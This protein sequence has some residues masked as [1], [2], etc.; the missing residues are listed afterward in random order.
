MKRKYFLPFLLSSFFIFQSQAQEV[1]G[2]AT[3]KS[4]RKVDIELD[5]TQMNDEMRA[6]VLAMLKKNFEKEYTLDF[7]KDESIYKEVENLDK[8]SVSTGGMEFVVATAGGSDILYKNTKE[9]KFVNQNDLFG[10]QFLIEDALENLDWQLEK[11]TKNIGEYT[12]FKAIAKRMVPVMRVIESSGDEEGVLEEPQEEEITLTAWYTPQIPVKH[13]PS[14]YGGLPGLI[15]EVS[16]GR[17]TILCSKIVLNPKNDVN[18]TAPSKG[19]KVSQA[20]FDEIMEKKMKEMDERFKNNRRGD[21]NNVE[22]RIG[23]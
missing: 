11:E 17:E 16:D 7:T 9:N 13:G 4:Q 1:K 10:K 8:P 6:Q 3:Y 12:C 23:G 21:G 20:E 18:V 2:I 19:K 15:L 22:I 5:S 14:E